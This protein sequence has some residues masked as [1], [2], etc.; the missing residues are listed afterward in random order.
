MDIFRD[1]QYRKSIKDIF[2]SIPLKKN[3]EMKYLFIYW[4]LA[5]L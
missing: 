5:K 3:T 2:K 4:K 1:F